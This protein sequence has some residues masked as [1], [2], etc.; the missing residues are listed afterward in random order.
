M[1]WFPLR[2]ALCYLIATEIAQG[3]SFSP[4]LSL[5][6]LTQHIW[7]LEH[8]SYCSYT[9]R[10]T[11]ART[12]HR[13]AASPACVD[14]L[15]INRHLSRVFFSFSFFFCI[16]FLPCTV[17]FLPSLREE[18]SPLIFNLFLTH[19]MI[20]PRAAGWLAGWLHWQLCVCVFWFG[21]VFVV[22]AHLDVGRR[23]IGF[24]SVR[25]PLVWTRKKSVSQHTDNI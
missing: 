18:H 25:C 8:N 3:P 10:H 2:V 22:C 21:S 19:C 12:P 20:I 15:R 14:A 17:F 24:F 9:H 16:W 4:G 1:K 23:E 11:Y 6:F 5:E 13:S 7:I